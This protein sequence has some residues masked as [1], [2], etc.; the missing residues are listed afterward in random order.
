[1]MLPKREGGSNYIQMHILAS[2]L[3]HPLMAAE[4]AG[5]KFITI[6]DPE[7]NFTPPE[8]AA[9]RAQQRGRHPSIIFDDASQKGRRHQLHPDAHS[10]IHPI[11]PPNGCG[12]GGIKF[13]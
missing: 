5:L 12:K 7:C 9:K 8:T 13:Y 2:I 3:S 6:V 4:R 1:M 10:R 11:P